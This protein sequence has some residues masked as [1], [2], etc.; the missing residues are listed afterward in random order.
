M[1]YIKQCYLRMLINKFS[2]HY[3]NTKCVIFKIILSVVKIPKTQGLIVLNSVLV[4]ILKKNFKASVSQL[5]QLL[6]L[7]LLLF[8]RVMMKTDKS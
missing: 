1:L 8:E 3:N 4:A 6:P 5:I 2:S 7:T